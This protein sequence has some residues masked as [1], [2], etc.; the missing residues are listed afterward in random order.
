MVTV[1]EIFP[2]GCNLAFFGK[3]GLGMYGQLSACGRMTIEEQNA[4]E[5]NGHG[6]EHP[7]YSCLV[8]KCSARKVDY[9]DDK[10]RFIIKPTKGPPLKL[11]SIFNI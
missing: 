7:C 5:L 4:N 10:K 6:V 1:K 3:Y 8:E 2:E 11:K 9:R